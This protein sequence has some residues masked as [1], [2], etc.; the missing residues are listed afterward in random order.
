M[1]RLWLDIRFV[2]RQLRKTPGFTIAA[3]LTLAL[4]IGA[5]TA[6]FSIVEGVLLRPLP[7][8]HPDRLV[9]VGDDLQGVNV[10]TNVFTTSGPE[11]AIYA[12]ETKAFQSLGGYKW[13]GFELSGAGEP[14]RVRAARL[15]ASMFDVLGVQPLRGRGFTRQ[16]DEGKEQ[17]A[18]I[19]YG[20]WRSRFHGEENILGQT[21]QLDRKPYEVIGVMPPEFEFPLEA[22]RLNNSELWVPMSF[23]TSDPGSAIRWDCSVAAR[24]KPGVTPAQAESDAMPA[25]EEITRNLPPALGSVRIRPVVKSL[26]EATVAGTRPML[27]IL[28]LAVAAVLFIG[29]ANLAGLLLLRVIQR[30]RE[31]AVRLALGATGRD[32]VRQPLV[33]ALALSVTGGGL[34]L[35]LACAF[36]KVGVSLLPESLPRVSSIGLDWAV[37]G[38]A[39]GL[40]IVTGLLCGV[41]PS[42]ASRRAN[43]NEAL[44]DGGRTASGGAGHARLRS[45]L[46][47]AE[48]AAALVLATAAGLLLRSFEKM[49]AVDLGFRADH[50]LTA[51]YNLPDQQYTTQAAV[52]AFNR[53]LE[54]KLNQMPGVEAVGATTMLPAAGPNNN[55]NAFVPEGYVAPKGEGPSLAWAAR[56]MGNYLKAAGMRMVRGRDFTPADGPGAPLVAIVNRKLAERYWPGQDPIGKRLHMGLKEMNLPWLTVVGVIGDVKDSAI[57]GETQS[58]IY[59][60]SSQDRTALGSYATPDYISGNYGAI[61]V[62]GMLPPEEMAGALRG[63]VGSIDPQLPLTRVEPMK[64]IVAEGEASRRFNTLLVSSFAALAILM[65]LMGIYSVIAFSAAMRTQEMAIRLALGSTRSSVMGLVLGTAAKLGLAGSAI[66]ALAAVLGTR[67][68]RSL[69]FQVDPLDPTVIAL[70]ALSIFALSLAA[71]LA[72]ARRVAAVDPVKAL[73]TE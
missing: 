59:T 38:F 61:V 5:T 72:P 40:A 24:L 67:L 37:A 50:M 62:R 46:V 41:V 17:V 14:V 20:M 36:I 57:E 8:P 27:R 29:S 66:G 42:L 73:R 16:E 32:V 12:R 7:F 39:V 69:L 55:W 15:T 49:R 47:V 3:V 10:G 33:E 56:V 2:V 34:G 26:R 45:G 58:Q 64:Q 23:D 13:E 25:A 43:M 51:H 48:V 71:A 9:A 70:A 35:A 53:T 31:T 44:K 28:F 30:R 54:E 1:N 52:D 6:I 65:A 18:V 21:I 60:P 11:V 63:A 4:G 19:S 22:G 68:L